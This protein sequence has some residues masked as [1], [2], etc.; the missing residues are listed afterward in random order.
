MSELVITNAR[1]VLRDEV[2]RGD[3]VAID[4]RIARVQPS[5]STSAVRSSLDFE[6]DFLLPGL[7]ELHTD[8]LECAA[9]PRPG[10]HWPAN[11][12]VV[13]HDLQMAAAGI[14]TVYDAVAVGDIRRGG[15]RADKLESMVGAIDAMQSAG[16]L[17][18]EHRLHLRCE[19]SFP[20]LQKL[21][22]Q[23]GSH[24][25]VGLISLMDH[26]PGQRQFVTLDQ[27]KLY[28]QGKYGLSDQEL[29]DFVDERKR[30]QEIYGAAN[31]DGVIALARRRGI[32][33]ASHDDATPAHV[34]E[35]VAAGVTIA[36]FPTTPEAAFAARQA[37]LKIVGGAPN[38]VRGRSH[39][40]NAS[41]L[42]FAR[43]GLLDILSSDYVPIALLQSAFRLADA[44]DG[45]LARAVA[46][47]SANPAEAVGLRDRGMI[48]EGRRADLVR[49]RKVSGLPVARTTW[50][51]G[52]RIA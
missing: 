6:G 48:E 15:D 42:E 38:L 46:V 16:S 23:F 2:V 7:I 17:R 30:E 25:L 40:G 8:N 36:E 4:G 13:A 52:E 45:N 37:G 49:V 39:S 19:L 22:A 34:E 11:S 31:R 14:T 33:L 20:E 28:Y 32:R 44:T 9:T 35:A 21:M 27:Y 24:P 47:V 18:A 51:A 29:V 41:A 3:V 50:R 1:L 12:A 43:T 5:S 10:V 26:T